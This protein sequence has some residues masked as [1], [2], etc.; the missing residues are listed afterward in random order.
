MRVL[1]IGATGLL[2]RV[3][4]DQWGSDEITGAGSHDAD[5][6]DPEQ[7]R[8]LFARSRPEWT[9]LAAAFTDVDGCEKDPERAHQVNCVGAVNVARAARESK[10]KLLFLS[11]DY[12]FDG[13][14]MLRT[15]LRM[16]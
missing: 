4:L 11:T 9:V 5:V 6:R 16:H 13:K 14:K 15:S 3:L 10:S 1:V 7:L 8:R 12:V 2:G